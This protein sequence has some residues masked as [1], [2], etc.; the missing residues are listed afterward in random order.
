MVDER[1]RYTSSIS[2]RHLHRS[3]FMD[4][5]RSTFSSGFEFIAHSTVGDHIMI[6]RTC[7]RI[8]VLAMAAS[9]ACATVSGQAARSWT[10]PRTADG[11]PD[12]QGV[13]TTST[14]TTLERPAEFGT[15]EI[16]TPA[17][18][19]AYE[20]RLLDQG[21]RDRRGRTAEADVGGAYNEFW[22]EKG[23]KVVE[24]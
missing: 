4:H 7:V 17:E 2:P 13:W 18:T 1:C 11:Q 20:H 19:A 3:S 10:P 21:N 8:I 22:F 14:L 23:S 24:T 9:L 15:R 5:L 6:P 16:L 12:L